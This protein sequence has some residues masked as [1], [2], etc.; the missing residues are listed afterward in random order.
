MMAEECGCT[1]AYISRFAQIPQM[2][3]RYCPRHDAADAMR[4]ALA[5]AERA[6]D[7]RRKNWPDK[8]MVIGAW[9]SVQAALALA[10]GD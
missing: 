6:L 10:D 4:F 9:E 2:E 5:L 8:L 3:I 1:V 7:I